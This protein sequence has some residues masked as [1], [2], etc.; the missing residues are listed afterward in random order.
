MK[1]I[2]FS[3]ILSLITASLFAQTFTRKNNEPADA[4]VKR[5]ANTNELAHPVIETKEWDS[6]KKAILYFVAGNNE[7][8]NFIVGHLLVPLALNTYKQVLIDTFWQN[9][10]TVSLTIETVLFANAD[11]DKRREIII[12]TRAQAHS[13]RFADNDLEGF[14]YQSF[15]YDDP[16]LQVPQSKLPP[17]PEIS[18]RFD[19]EFEGST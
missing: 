2:L 14:Y 15:V 16:N 13:P 19:E 1:Q 6:L 17:L 10:G 11:N 4:F 8:D 12:M 7:T 5:I 18:K 9:G 3:L